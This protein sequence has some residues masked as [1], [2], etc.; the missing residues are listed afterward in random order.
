[1][2]KVIE[3]V[4]TFFNQI[5]QNEATFT[6]ALNNYTMCYV[7]FNIS[8][9]TSDFQCS[10]IKQG[11]TCS[12]CMTTSETIVLQ[13]ISEIQ[14]IN[15]KIVKNTNQL[16]AE[17]DKGAPHK[18]TPEELSKEKNN[19][20]NLINRYNTT[21]ES[22]NNSVELYKIYRFQLLN[23]VIKSLSIIIIIFYL[24][25]TTKGIQSITFLV[26]IAYMT[27]M[28]L[29]LFYPNSTIFL[30]NICILVFFILCMIMNVN[31]IRVNYQNVKDQTLGTVKKISNELS[32][33]TTINKL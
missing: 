15:K 32:K 25:S 1:M 21:N 10:S 19:A 3:P 6:A 24:L 12:D 27:M 33:N 28:T 7:N 11:D 13:A 14:N 26:L 29:E 30:I 9:S 18:P 8:E 17:K 20:I 31:N 2:S 4:E 5:A 23:E 16:V 22:L